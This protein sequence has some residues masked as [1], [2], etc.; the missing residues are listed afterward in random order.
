MID[1]AEFTV[2]AVAA[3]EP[4]I[5]VAPVANPVPVMIMLVPPAVGP[6]SGLTAVTD[7]T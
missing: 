3:T 4:N 7:G 2:T 5:T 6:A 1:V